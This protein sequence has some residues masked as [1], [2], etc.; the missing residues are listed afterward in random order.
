[1]VVSLLNIV[2]NAISD[3]H[4][5]FEFSIDEALQR[6]H[7]DIDGGIEILKLDYPDLKDLEYVMVYNGDTCD[8]NPCNDYSQQVVDIM[9]GLIGD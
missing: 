9:K 4:D 6:V 8:F 2:V 3:H 5:I 1:M 7:E